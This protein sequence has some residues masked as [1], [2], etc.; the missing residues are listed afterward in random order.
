MEHPLQNLVAHLFQ[1]PADSSARGAWMAASAEFAGNFI[2]VYAIVFG[3]HAESD[4]ALW[5]FL[6]KQRDHDG[7]DGADGIN[8]AVDIIRMNIQALLGFITESHA[9]DFIVRVEPGL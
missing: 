8:Q 2:H 1:V 5:Q 6:K 4:F 7:F 9:R 3:P